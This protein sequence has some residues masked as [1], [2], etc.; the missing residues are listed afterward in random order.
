[1]SRSRNSIPRSSPTRSSTRAGSVTVRVFLEHSCLQTET[2]EDIA[3]IG[4]GVGRRSHGPTPR[5]HPGRD[6][7]DIAPCLAVKV[8]V[9][10]IL[11]LAFGSPHAG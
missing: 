1:M 8:A 2:A 11:E 4:Q 9:E 10:A 3:T 5:E 7:G 6:L